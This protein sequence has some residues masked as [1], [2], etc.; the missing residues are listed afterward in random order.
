MSET[1]EDDE[2]VWVDV[3]DLEEMELRIIADKV[4]EMLTRDLLIERERMGL[5][6]RWSGWRQS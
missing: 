5:S 3:E 1:R 2:A 6:E 4:M